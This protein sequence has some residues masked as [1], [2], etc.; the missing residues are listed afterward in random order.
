MEFRQLLLE[1][2][3]EEMPYW[4]V[5]DGIDYLKQKLSS[6]FAENNLDFN[7]LKVYGGPRRFVVSAEI[8]ALTSDQKI[9]VKGPAFKVAYDENGNP[10]QAAAGFARSQG[11]AVEELKVEEINGGKYVV[12]EKIIKGKPAAAFLKEVLPDVISKFSFKKSMRWGSGTFRFVRPIRWILCLVD[13]EVIEFEIAG[14]RSDNKTRGHRLYASEP[15]TVAAAGD[16][17]DVVENKGRV[18][19]D[20]EKRRQTII[21]AAAEAV[22]KLDAEPIISEETLK[23]VV[24][25]V[26]WPEI[27]VGGFPEEFL[28][29][30]EEVLITVMQHHQRYFP[31]RQKSGRL[32][33]LFVVVHNGRP[34]NEEIIREGNERVVLARLEDA[35]FFYQEDLKKPL[36]ARVEGLKGVVFQQKLGTLYEKTLRNQKLVKPVAVELGLKPDE[37]ERAKRAAY[38]CKADLLTEM[39]NEFDELQGIMGMYYALKSGEDERVAR[40][41]FEHYL[42]RFYGDDLPS[43]PEGKALSIADRLDTVCGYFLAGLEPTGS[44]DPYS[45]RRQAQGICL[46]ILDSG[47][48]FNLKKAVKHSLSLYEGIQGLAEK[49]RAEESLLEFFKARYQRLLTEKGLTAPVVQAVLPEVLERPATALEKARVITSYLGTELLED[50]LTAFQR[51]KNLSR[52]ELGTEYDPHYLEEKEELELEKALQK[53][54][55]EF[56]EADFE[57]QLKILASLRQPID[58]FFDSVLVMHEDPNVR[59][60]R[61][62]LLNRLLSLYLGFADFSAL[63]Q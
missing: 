10:T 33:N 44:E 15:L 29:L 49:S 48:D 21:S 54:A 55:A 61:L 14:V 47:I 24:H 42:P 37:I 3:T 23:E 9:K 31:V 53:A 7:N 40:A 34:E 13:A 27:V 35:R 20:Q 39:V 57:E 52:P 50:I 58:A 17:F 18:M 32:S 4:A 36:E 41:I 26:E 43:T 25:L 30:P 12:A 59:E 56:H 51:V 19:V 2:G 63:R 38:L 8:A 28:E 22:K 16:Y 62:K 45:L 6:V 5:Y 60:N 11:V 1:I 46:V